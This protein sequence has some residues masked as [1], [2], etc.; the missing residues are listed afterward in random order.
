VSPE[1]HRSLNVL[2]EEI[3]ADAKRQTDR[4]RRRAEREAKAILDDA[5]AAA[6]K[7]R[8]ERVSD[9]EADAGRRRTVVLAGVPIEIG[10]M[11]W[12]RMEAELRGIHD[13]VRDRLARREALD[14]RGAVVALASEAVAGMEGDR[15]VIALAEADRSLFDD[16]LVEAIRRG[17]GR[18]GVAIEPAPEAAPIAAGV[19]VRDPEGRQVWDQSLAVRLDRLWPELRNALAVRAGMIDRDDETPEPKA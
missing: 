3:L 1:E 10:R 9:A 15:F 4:T 11:H 6:D 12:D 7:E 14:A 19:I 17:A 8:C 13:D 16:A 18:P 2:R 5:R